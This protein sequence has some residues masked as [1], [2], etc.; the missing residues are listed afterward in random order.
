M[1][2]QHVVQAKSAAVAGVAD[3]TALESFGIKNN[4]I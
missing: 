1:H 2:K 4:I 3:R